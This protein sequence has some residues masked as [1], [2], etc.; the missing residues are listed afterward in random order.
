MYG[1]V[2]VWRIGGEG[3]MEKWEGRL[4][5]RGILGC[6]KPVDKR[7]FPTDKYRSEL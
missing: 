4:D 7:S 2:G 5:V 1:R 3:R 6:G